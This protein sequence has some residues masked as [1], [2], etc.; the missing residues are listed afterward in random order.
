MV[1]IECQMLNVEAEYRSLQLRLD[2]GKHHIGKNDD[3]KDECNGGIYPEAI[4]YFSFFRG[5]LSFV[6]C[7]D[8]TLYSADQHIR[9]AFCCRAICCSLQP[10]HFQIHCQPS[11]FLLH[12]SPVQTGLPTK[13][14]H[15]LLVVNVFVTI[16]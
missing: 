4:V 6:E 10:H 15:Q 8:V 13:V 14:I 1:N 9:R 7:T 16:G 11:T 12:A 3:N 2:P 5:V